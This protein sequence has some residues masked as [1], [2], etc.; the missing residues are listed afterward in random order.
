MHQPPINSLLH[1]KNETHVCESRASLA[2]DPLDGIAIRGPE[3][4][5]VKSLHKQAISVAWGRA[6]GFAWRLRHA[7]T[8]IRGGAGIFYDRIAG[9]ITVPW[10]RQR[11]R[12][13]I[14]NPRIADRR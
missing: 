7:R 8:A 11:L 4:L 10:K 3:R 9:Q 1:E 5:A 14:Y 6:F 2:G 13:V 12:N